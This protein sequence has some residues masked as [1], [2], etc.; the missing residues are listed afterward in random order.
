MNI[1]ELLNLYEDDINKA[2][3][4]NSAFYRSYN[5]TIFVSLF[6]PCALGGNAQIILLL[7]I[8]R[9]TWI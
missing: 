7:Y 2:N 5:T 8:D 3:Y 9:N 4:G 6:L 1:N